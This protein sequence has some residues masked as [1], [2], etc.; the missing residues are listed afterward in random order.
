[1]N[2][3]EMLQCRLTE[4][5]RILDEI[6]KIE[7]T[8]FTGLENGVIGND[9]LEIEKQ[10]SAKFDILEDE[11]EEISFGVM[12]VHRVNKLVVGIHSDEMYMAERSLVKK[13]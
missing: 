12:L 9:I 5:I 10:I 1:M 4:Y 6:L 2:M 8:H 7:E 13:S 3:Q 11:L